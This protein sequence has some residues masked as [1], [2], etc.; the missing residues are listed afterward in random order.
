MR[1][2]KERVIDAVAATKAAIEEG[3]VPGG[4]VALLNISQKM[5]T[6]DLGNNSASRD[7]ITG[8]EIVKSAI[9]APF[10]QLITNAGL[11]SGELIAKAREAT[12]KSQGFNVLKIESVETAETVDMI[13]E[14]IIDPV[15]VVRTAVQNAVSVAGMILT[16]EAVV[17]DDPDAKKEQTS[18]GGMG[19]MGM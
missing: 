3:I 16:T 10:C 6:I 8:F 12:S 13:K 15:K 4:G 9:E 17:Y 2:K 19:D 7:E 14:G 18:M 5:A 1:E 11:S